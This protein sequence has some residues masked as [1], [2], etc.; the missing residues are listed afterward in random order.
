MKRLII[1]MGLL[2]C[3]QLIRAQGI[4]YLNEPS[5]KNP[6]G[7]PHPNA[8]EQIK[9]FSELIG[10][11][12]CKSITRLDKDTWADSVDMTWTFKYIMDG[13]AVQDETLKSDGK[14]SGSIRQFIA[15][16]SK[17]Y[18]HYYSSAT[19]TTTLSTWEGNKNEDGNIVLYR[20]QKAPN[21]ME[22]W[23]RLTFSDMSDKG[24]HWVGEW[25]TKD[26]TFAYPTWRIFCKRKSGN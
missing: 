20:D 14:H 2:F 19:P 23:Y 26:E 3:F 13:M 17:W 10:T 5:E 1:L 4:Q 16:S 8:P 22:G 12:T 7:Q 24:F 15:D 6:F 9:D 11:C 25:T 18:V 21:G